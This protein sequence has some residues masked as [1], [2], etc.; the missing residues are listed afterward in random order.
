M[1]TTSV[2]LLCPS[3]ICS[4]IVLITGPQLFW[5]HSLLTIPCTPHLHKKEYIWDWAYLWYVVQVWRHV[6]VLSFTYTLQFCELM[7]LVCHIQL[8]N[9][10]PPG[11]KERKIPK[12]LFFEL[13]SVPNYFFEIVAWIGFT[14]LTQA[15][16]S[17]LFM[18]IGA[19]QMWFWAVTKHRRYKKDFDGKEGRPLYPK[20]R[21]VLVPFLF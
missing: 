3:S 4:R 6:G 13:V 16:T 7:N 21:K 18:L 12:G 5:F 10:R 19:V 1:C 2:T 20:N 15:F 9:L 8:S 11:S 14:I 17:A